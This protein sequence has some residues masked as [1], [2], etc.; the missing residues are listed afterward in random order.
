MNSP[1]GRG[2]GMA[3]HGGGYGTEKIDQRSAYPDQYRYIV[4][5]LIY[6]RS[7]NYGN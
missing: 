6:F 4:K 7:R 1:S 5:L 2:Y 3:Q